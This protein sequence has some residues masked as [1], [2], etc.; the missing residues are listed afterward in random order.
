MELCMVLITT[1][2]LK[3]CLK[4]RLEKFNHQEFSYPRE[5][6][7]LFP[8]TPSSKALALQAAAHTKYTIDVA[9]SNLL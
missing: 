3:S 5:R 2:E 4:L 1:K 6:G 7:H 9:Y 8:W